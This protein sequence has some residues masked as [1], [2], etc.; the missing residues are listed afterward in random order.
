VNDFTLSEEVI[1]GGETGAG[2]ADP[3][4]Y[5]DDLVVKHAARTGVNVD[6]LRA[7]I[8]AESSW[9]PKAIGAGRGAEDRAIGIAQILRS[10]AEKAG[11][12]P[13][14]PDHAIG[15]M[16]DRAVKALK[17][18]KGNYREVAGQY[19]GWNQRGAPTRTYQD[20]VMKFFKQRKPG[21]RADFSLISSA[22][23]EELPAASPEF[24]LS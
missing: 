7:Q 12:D 19:H 11:V 21:K 14:N 22:Q 2:P 17:K 4:A 20:R 24:T 9:N 1:G 10:E 6:F 8:D 23:A 5:Y 18:Y 15:Y 13:Y 16:A 3:Q